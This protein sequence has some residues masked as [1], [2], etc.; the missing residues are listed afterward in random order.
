MKI[1]NILCSSVILNVNHN[2]KEL[3][4][5]LKSLKI[6]LNPESLKFSNS[7]KPL[8]LNKFLKLNLG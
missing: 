7:N 1:L 3:N 5:K 6:K 4:F 2:F 8:R